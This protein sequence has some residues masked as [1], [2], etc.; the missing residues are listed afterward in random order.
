M[1]YQGRR[2]FRKG[3]GWVLFFVGLTG[4]FAL[5]AYMTWQERGWTWVSVG[6]AGAAVVL[7]LGSILETLVER[8]ELTDEALVVT[9]LTGR[10]RYSRADIVRIEESKG[11]PPGM[12]LSSGRWVKLPSVA[13]S[14]GNSI[15]AWLKH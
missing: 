12:L 11:G 3:P 5:G 2:L 7:G 1:T 8:I 9:R 14:L 13:G 4:L 15:R 6:L 10:R